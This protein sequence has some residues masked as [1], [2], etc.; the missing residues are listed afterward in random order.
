[1]M[2]IIVG[3][4]KLIGMRI[5]E[6]LN[7]RYK[8]YRIASNETV[9]KLKGMY[10]SVKNWPNIGGKSDLATKNVATIHRIVWTV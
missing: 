10:E 9:M 6:Y 1:M 3:H 5:T 7:I 2:N 4:C 8:I